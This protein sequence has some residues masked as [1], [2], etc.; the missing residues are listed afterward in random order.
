MR[1]KGIAEASCSR[2]DV[3]STSALKLLLEHDL[4][5]REGG[6]SP[7]TIEYI[8]HLLEERDMSLAAARDAVDVEAAWERLEKEL[9][10]FHEN[11][12]SYPGEEVEDEPEERAPKEGKR[13]TRKFRPV[14]QRVGLIAA[15]ICIF[16]TGMLSVQAAGI[17]VFGTLA[18]WTNET[19]HFETQVAQEPNSAET[20]DE[21]DRFKSVLN[22]YSLD[23]GLAPSWLP[24]GYTMSNVEVYQDNTML[25]V[26]SSCKNAEDGYFG[27]QILRYEDA[28]RLSRHTFEKSPEKVETVLSHGK[29]FYILTNEDTLTATWSDGNVLMSIAGNL[30][31]E[32]L[33]QIIKS[34]GGG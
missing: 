30:P 5:D 28:K 32:D 12:G 31:R 2:L 29:Q 22:A 6:L 18:R 7:E 13:A 27:I 9:I 24:D 19:F 11:G 34:I 16:F 3:L 4:N 21:L 33:V 8:V 23:P 15:T 26:F 1:N 10:P 20:M 17:D 25:Q 14:L